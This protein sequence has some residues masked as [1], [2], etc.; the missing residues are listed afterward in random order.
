MSFSHLLTEDPFS[1]FWPEL[2]TLTQF[3]A[4]AASESESAASDE[5]V[6][7]ISLQYG[8]GVACYYDYYKI[9]TLSDRSVV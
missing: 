8:E 5:P 3:E 9:G 6:E 1:G 2:V 7:W 4:L